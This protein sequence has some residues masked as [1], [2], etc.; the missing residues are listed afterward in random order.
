MG[1]TCSEKGMMHPFP[2]SGLPSYPPIHPFVTWGFSPSPLW[3]K[4]HSKNSSLLNSNSSA[5]DA[6]C[7]SF[8][9]S[10]LQPEQKNSTASSLT[11]GV[12]HKQ[13][14]RQL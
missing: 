7:N 10:H 9:I 14:R 12:V 4:A 1:V 8:T 11:V 3:E 5:G 2:I 6:K 13:G